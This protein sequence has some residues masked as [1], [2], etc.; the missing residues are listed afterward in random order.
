MKL[1]VVSIPVSSLPEKLRGARRVES[2]AL[3]VEEPE[4]QQVQ[5]RATAHASGCFGIFSPRKVKKLGGLDEFEHGLQLGKWFIN[6]K[7][8]TRPEWNPLFF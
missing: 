8:K 6:K 4:L 1:Q 7:K 2:L 5:L 3:E